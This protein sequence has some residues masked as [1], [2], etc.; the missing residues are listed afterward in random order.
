[1]AT[2]LTPA[3]FRQDLSDQTLTEIAR[4]ER[5]QMCIHLMGMRCVW[6][7]ELQARGIS[8][9]VMDDEDFDPVHYGLARR[10]R[11]SPKIV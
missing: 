1:M 11:P 2:R 7:I 4:D 5:K 8:T 3:D 6:G 9:G 10:A